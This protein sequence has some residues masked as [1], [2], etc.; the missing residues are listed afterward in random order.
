MTVALNKLRV[1]T[2]ACYLRD[3]L[4]L[5]L[6]AGIT[7]TSW[8]DQREFNLGIDQISIEVA[9][10]FTNKVFAINGQLSGHLIHAQRG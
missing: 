2:V 10:S 6:F 4:M 1:S 9:P 5:F 8:A 3:I 7:T